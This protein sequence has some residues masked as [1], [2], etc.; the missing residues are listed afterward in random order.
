V[1]RAC[2]QFVVFLY[3][4]KVY[5]GKIINL[6]AENLYISPWWEV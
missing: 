5:P 2:G 3:E 4:G 6:K 1:V